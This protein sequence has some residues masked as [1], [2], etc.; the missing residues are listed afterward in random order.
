MVL[1]GIG[2]AADQP[3]G[4]KRT[5]PF[6]WVDNADKPV[7]I[8][9][10]KKQAWAKAIFNQ[11]KEAVDKNI[12]EYSRDVDLYLRKL[13]FDWSTAKDGRHPQFYYINDQ[14]SERKVRSP[15]MGY[16]QS[17]IESGVLYYL[18]GEE[19]YGQYSADICYAV[20]EAMARMEI[21]EESKL[22]GGYI[23][24]KDHLK[25]ARVFGAQIPI[26]HDFVK[27][28]IEKGGRPYSLMAK[29]KADFNSANAQKVFG[30]YAYLAL[31]RGLKDCNWPVLE[32]ASL[33]HNALALD[34][35]N[36]REKYLKIILTEGSKNQDSIR[37]TAEFFDQKSGFWPE[38]LQY[39]D[40]VVSGLTYHMAVLTKYNPSWRLAEKYPFVPMAFSRAQ[41][42][43]YPNGDFILYGDGY[44]HGGDESIKGAE[45]AYFISVR[46]SL[47][48]ATQI[49]GDAIVTAMK[50]GGYNRAKY[51]GR[52]GEPLWW[53]APLELLWREPTVE[54]KETKNEAYYQTD[55]LPF[56]GI[57]LQRNLSSTKDPSDALMSFVGGA[58]FVHGH[59]S[60]MNMELYGAGQVLGVKG[61]HS[62]YGSEDHDNYYRLFAG[63]NTVIVNGESQGEGGWI[64]LKINTVALVSMEPMPRAKAVSPDYSYSLTSFRDD[65]GDKAEADQQR[66]MSIVR[67]SPSSGYYVDVFRSRSD[68]PQPFHDYIYHG[69]ADRIVVENTGMAFADTPERYKSCT[70]KKWT[71]RTYR[72]PGWHYFEQVKTA[73]CGEDVKLLFP[74]S[75]LPLPA[76]MRLYVVGGNG[77]E[78]STVLAP[79]TTEAPNPYNDKKAT[80]PTVV[81]RQQGEAWNRPFA[82]VYEPIK[83]A[84]GKGTIQSV[85]KL[86]ADGQFCGFE[87]VSLISGKA[88]RQWVVIPNGK[89]VMITDLGLSFD[90]TYAVVSLDGG[91][92]KSIYMGLGRSLKYGKYSL[93]CDSPGSVA[94]LLTDKKHTIGANGPGTLRI[95]DAEFRFA[96][97]TIKD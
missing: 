72:N 89:P 4:H 41:R 22:N 21:K 91:Q 49:C 26:L 88:L 90:G 35:A 60:G 87:I 48:G 61:G 19:Q 93:L 5:H 69:L 64:N 15:L 55:D 12:A 83:N 79:R 11:M 86:S 85:K 75:H 81:I 34:D 77:R 18:T 32:G 47:P 71:N 63:H 95:A 97:D 9:K 46:Q 23:Y 78:I 82:V 65:G 6:I 20:I 59:A 44:R 96:G 57:Y 3:A 45:M 39:A 10:I 84:D 37:E 8:E 17:G 29:G 51:S 92:L 62:T 40:G 16:L 66:L 25:E 52:S 53:I 80:T 56:A 1:A 74:A 2:F 24:L 38:S 50:K 30:N 43:R 31:N 7:I 13:P 76:A 94:I 68:L 36:L 70:A 28:F 33:I 54:G 67:T 58:G 27:P 73:A 14:D 42:L